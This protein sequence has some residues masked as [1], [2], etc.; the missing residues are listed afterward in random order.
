[1]PL[2]RRDFL[3][4]LALTPFAPA[5]WRAAQQPTAVPPTQA[6]GPTAAAPNILLFVMDAFSASH[7]SLHGYQRETTPNLARFAEKAVVYHNHYAG[8]NF[9]SAGTASLL[10]G[11]YPWTNRAFNIRST[12]V[13]PFTEAKYLYHRWRSPLIIGWPTP[14]TFWP[15]F[16]STNSWAI[17][18]CYCPWSGFS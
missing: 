8:G 17:L 5:V 15:S 1:M 4:F 14:T 16:C 3:R 2:S 12:V 18:N 6:T 11:T 13:P 7:T 10:T 9:T